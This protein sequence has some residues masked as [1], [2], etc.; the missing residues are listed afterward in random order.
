MSLPSPRV[1]ELKFDI[2]GRD[3]RRFHSR[4]I[5]LILTGV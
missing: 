5:H 2:I 4:D 3:N 1:P